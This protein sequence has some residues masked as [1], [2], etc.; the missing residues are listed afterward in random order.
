MMTCFKWVFTSPLPSTTKNNAILALLIDCHDPGRT[1]SR[2]PN[3][4]SGYSIIL[5]SFPSTSL[6]K[7]S[8]VKHN[9]R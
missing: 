9:N 7:S 3:I 5:N 2:E 1:V 4:H 6:S 8:T